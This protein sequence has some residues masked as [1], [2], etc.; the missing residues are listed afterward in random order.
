MRE[1]NA[2]SARPSQEWR[3]EGAPTT[4]E[5][6]LVLLEA[7]ELAIVQLSSAQLS[8]LPSSEKEF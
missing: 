7:N 5:A 3:P 8:I 4:D 2:G 6:L 1:Y